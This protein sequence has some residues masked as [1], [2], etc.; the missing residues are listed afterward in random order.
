MIKPLRIGRGFSY[1]W[2][3]EINPRNVVEG[4][5]HIPIVVAGMDKNIVLLPIS[6]ISNRYL[7]LVH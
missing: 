4:Q 1:E 3:N 7:L 5:E 2:P 6:G